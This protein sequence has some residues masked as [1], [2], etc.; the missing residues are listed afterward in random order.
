[1]KK[2]LLFFLCFGFVQ[3]TPLLYRLLF[4][5]SE[6]FLYPSLLCHTILVIPLFAVFYLRNRYTKAFL[7]IW[8]SWLYVGELKILTYYNVN[9][10]Y[11]SVD[12]GCII[13]NLFLACM[14]LGM[15]AHDL[16]TPPPTL[17][18]EVR[19]Q[20]RLFIRDLG[21]LE[22]V[23]IVFPLL[24]FIDFIRAVGFIPIFAG[25]DVTNIMYEIKYGFL[26][27]YGFLNCVAAVL[28]YDRYLR[29]SKKGW[30]ILWLCLLAA[31]L[32]IMSIDSKRLFLLTALLAVFVYGKIMAGALTIN[33]STLTMLAVATV[34]YVLLQNLRLGDAGDSFFARD[35]LPLGAEFREYIRAVNEFKPGEIPN[36][37]FLSSTIGGFVNGAFLRLV[38]Y[39]KWDLVKHDS[40]Y[41]FMTLFDE[42]NTL[43]IRTGFSSEL[44]FA[45]GFYG[46][47]VIALFGVVISYLSY[48]I[49]NVRNQSSL[50][51]LSV[52]WGLLVL[53]VF[54][55]SSVTVGCLCI[56]LYLYIL[57]R[58][59]KL[60]K[61]Q[62]PHEVSP[63]D[64][65][66]YSGSQPETAHT[67]LPGLPE[68]ANRYQL[69]N[70]SR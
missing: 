43:G 8:I 44:Y 35:G 10:Y 21:W 28:M 4:G 11:I 26:Y 51:L 58:L 33:R 48:K 40:A 64:L 2:A 53:S 6:E 70:G 12:E 47:I 46:L 32:L 22:G 23:L 30:K 14:S 27:S 45:Y 59:I 15:L 13:Y 62:R 18:P 65:R 55:Q 17:T 20:G 38:G 60:A 7:V 41:S 66:R 5:Y 39:D 19:A 57:I 16:L 3:V 63:Y 24:W 37:N 31:S 56:L 9:P 36:Y 29:S 54:G 42:E 68:S 34:F 61:P 52:T 50:I 25:T 67:E 49:S 69:P 1:M